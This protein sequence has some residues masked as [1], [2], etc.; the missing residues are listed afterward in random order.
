MSRC[1]FGLFE[2]DMATGDLRRAGRPVH[3]APQPSRVLIALVERAGEVVTRDELKEVVWGDNTFVDFEQ[4][5]NFCIKQLRGALG[6]EAENPRFVETVPRRGYRFIAPV[7]RPKPEVADD[8][9]PLASGFSTAGALAEAVSRTAWTSRALIAIAILLLAIAGG[10]YAWSRASRVAADPGKVM[11]A[12]LPFKNLSTDADQEYFSDGFT[13]ELITQLSRTD[14]T[15]LGVIAR[16]SILSYRNTTK[17]VAD[18]G[19]ELGVQHVVEGTIRKGGDRVRINAQLIR[20]SDQSHVWADVYEGE[21]RDILR[22]QREVGDAVARQILSVLN[23]A[24]MA[25]PKPVDPAV[26]DLYLRA[27]YAWNTRQGPEITKATDLFREAVHRDPAF[28]R[29]WAGLADA[30]M[31]HARSEALEAAE[32]AIALDDRLADAHVAKAEVLTHMLRWDW[33]DQEFRRAL[34]LD[35]SYVPGRYF[36]AEHLAARG[37]RTQAI[38]E[39]RHALALDPKSA[40]AAHVVGVTHYYGGAYAEALP[41]LRKALELDPQH[42]WS[43]HRIGLVLE[44]QRAF[45]LAF[46][47]FVAGGA[48]LRYAYAYAVAGDP[49]RARQIINDALKQP[50]AV[51]QAYHLAGAYVGLGEY[52]EALKWLERAV[53]HQLHDVIFLYVDPRFEPLRPLAKYREL[54]RQGGWE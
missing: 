53:A 42:A 51:A 27:R 7:V 35:P 8:S 22:V 45:D 15:H 37:R 1:S 34:A 21:L 4:G 28:A 29:G 18:I 47:E 11:I 50:D 48:P 3:L 19:R 49:P 23:A 30:L 16:T 6:D 9:V 2:L 52:D 39:A 17:S 36:Y 14:P 25:S 40:I 31:V 46:P 43:H 5:L 24:N 44:R 13:D 20:V 32:R 26:Y 33:A 41:Y 10:Y 54:I 38:D 12:V